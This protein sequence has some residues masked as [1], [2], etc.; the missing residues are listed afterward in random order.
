[1]LS[2]C[3]AKKCNTPCPIDSEPLESP[4]SSI[5]SSKEILLHSIPRDLHFGTASRALPPA[6]PSFH[7]A[8]TWH[9]ALPHL[10]VRCVSAIC[11]APDWRTGMSSALH[12]CCPFSCKYPLPSSSSVSASSLRT[13]TPLLVIQPSYS[14]VLGHS[15]QSSSPYR[16]SSPSAAPTKFPHLR[17]LQ[18]PFERMCTHNYPY[19]HPYCYSSYSPCPQ[20]SF[21]GQ[22]IS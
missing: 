3:K 7:S 18:L 2:S 8:S 20:F 16:L 21:T 13:Y 9:S 22:Y 10:K 17:P 19:L 1:M 11:A 14:C 12:R 5:N 15:F 6:H 4:K